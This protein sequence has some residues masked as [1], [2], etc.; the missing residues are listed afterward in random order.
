VRAS[1]PPE[2]EQYL[3]IIIFVSPVWR[4][5]VAWPI[6]RARFAAVALSIASRAAAARE[7]WVM[8]L[9]MDLV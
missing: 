7:D 2:P 6:S 1:S 4:A 3:L 5:I 9:R 8:V